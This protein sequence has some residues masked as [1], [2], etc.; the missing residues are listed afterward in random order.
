MQPGLNAPAWQTPEQDL[1]VE[2]DDEVG[3]VAAVRHALRADADAI[4]ACACDA[5]RAAE[6]LP[7]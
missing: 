1:L 7:G 5:A 4:A 6:S 2:R 3:F